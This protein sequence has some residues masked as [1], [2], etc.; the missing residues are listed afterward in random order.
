MI[1]DNVLFSCNNMHTFHTQSH[2]VFLFIQ[3]NIQHCGQD[4]AVTRNNYD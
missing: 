3:N 4:I 2:C 1:A